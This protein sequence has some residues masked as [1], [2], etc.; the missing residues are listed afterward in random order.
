MPLL[1]P[2]ASAVL[3][4]A[5]SALSYVNVMDYDQYGYKPSNF[6]NCTWHQGAADDC[7]LD[8]LAN[9]AAVKMPQGGTFPTSQIVMGLMIGPA[10]DGAVITPKEAAA[11]AAWVRAHGY[12]GVMIWDVDRDGAKTTGHPKGA[13][14]KAISQA[15]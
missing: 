10:D 15:L 13:Y 1:T 12:G 8:V 7:Y 6:P 3:Q 4:N 9:F 14:I 5:A 2:T 11:Y